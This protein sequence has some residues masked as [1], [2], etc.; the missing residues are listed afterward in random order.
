MQTDRELVDA[1]GRGDRNAFGR[2]IERYQRAVY[3]VAY[4][5]LRDR[6]LADD[7]TQETFVT[8]WRLLQTLRDASK[9][10]P[11]LCGI[12]RN[13]ARDTSKLQRRELARRERVVHSDP[14]TPFEKL[15]AAE[16]EQ[17]VAAALGNMPDRYREPLVLFYVEE[18]SADEVA[19][20]LGIA[21]ATV[22]QRLS[23]GRRHLA[24]RM[25]ELAERSLTIHGP[26]TGLVAAVLA[27]IASLPPGDAHAAAEANAPALARSGL[28]VA[29]IVV[30]A[31]AAAVLVIG[32][33]RVD[34]SAAPRPASA[35]APAPA[36]AAPA[37]AH[38]ATP[39]AKSPAAPASASPART[40]PA[41]KAYRPQ[42]A[43]APAPVPTADCTTVADHVAQ[44]LTDELNKRDPGNDSDTLRVAALVRTGLL[45]DCTAEK[46]DDSKRRCYVTADDYD[47]A[48]ID[49]EAAAAA[50][51]AEVDR[52]PARLSCAAVVGHMV[53]LLATEIRSKNAKASAEVKEMGEKLI[54]GRREI[55]MRACESTPWAAELRTCIV[56]ATTDSAANACK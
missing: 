31:S 29:E 24:G 28:R 7:V 36:G 18:R 53:D 1:V 22:H 44:L 27:A 10:A 30:A 9:L 38:P 33:S 52:L 25:A 4:S 20:I 35:K 32:V 55:K 13:L 5:R 47:D 17:L 23:R 3:A 26:S 51:T 41:H 15:D 8:A 14:Q 19:R 37:P 39:P 40:R 34:A 6:A 49:C 42:L 43:P 56:K 45:R 12:A 16:L 21:P 50:T 54:S 2:L 11:W 46:W 48:R